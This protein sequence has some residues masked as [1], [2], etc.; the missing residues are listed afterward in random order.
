MRSPAFKVPTSKGEEGRRAAEGTS[1]D[2]LAWGPQCLNPALNSMGAIPSKWRCG[3]RRMASA[4][5]GKIDK[6]SFKIKVKVKLKVTS[7]CIALLR[8]RL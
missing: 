8:K 1:R 4:E 2:H 6:G 5:C 7:I 3:R